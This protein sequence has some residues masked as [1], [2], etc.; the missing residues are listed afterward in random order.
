ME[1]TKEQIKK[2][3]E[4]K[5]LEEFKALAKAEGVDFSDEQAEEYFNATRVGELND[6]NLSA[7]AGG[8]GGPGGWVLGY[9]KIFT[10]N[11]PF[12]LQALSIDIL[13]YEHTKTREIKVEIRPTKCTKC[14]A[15]ISVERFPDRIVFKKNGQVHKYPF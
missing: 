3:S 14:A 4:C 9:K 15:E 7:V 13:F 6:D 5:T 1:F 10:C 12:C 11:C 2:A 8:K